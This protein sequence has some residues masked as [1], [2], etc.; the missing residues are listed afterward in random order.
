MINTIVKFTGIAWLALSLAAAAAWAGS[1]KLS[2]DLRSR[3]LSDRLDVIVRYNVTPTDAHHGKVEKQGG[4]LRDK[5]DVIKAGHY[6][7]PRSA[8]DTLSDDPDAAYISPNRGLKAMLDISAGAVHADAANSLGFVGK[9]IGVAVIDSGIADMPDFQNNRSRIVYA[10]SFVLGGISDQYG[11][12]THVAGIIGGNGNGGV[13]IGM[14]PEVNLINLRALDA[15]GNGTDAQVI[16]AIGAAINLRARFNIRVINLSLGRAVFEPAAQD[17]LC[18][19]VEAAWK[20]GIVV[21]VAAGN[22]GRDNYTTAQG[23][24]TIT[25]PG[26]DPYAITVGAMKTEGTKTRTDDLIASYS[27]KGPTLF[28]HYVKPDLVAPGNRVV[29]TMPARLVLSGGYPHGHVSGNYFTLSGTSMASAVVSGAA[30]LL[31]QKNP[32]LTPDQIKASLMRTATSNFPLSSVATDSATGTNYTSY[33]D[34][35]TV[36]AGYLDITGALAHNTY[37]A[38][39][40]LSPSASYDAINRDVVL[41][42]SQSTVGG[43]YVVTGTNVVWGSD[44]NVVWGGGSAGTSAFNAIW[45][46]NVVWSTAQLNGEMLSVLGEQ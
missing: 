46:Y 19:A 34:V 2:S 37:A 15:T 24:G 10:A 16:Q 4:A 41:N 45:G 21:V 20:A 42:G 17:P 43:T 18:Q 5:L 9:G 3:N 13:Y 22:Q 14:A 12:G 8:L 27:S 26:N 30:A 33:Y 11:H 1:E 32:L 29:S 25:A 35:F 44:K 40:A 6:T 28:D 39:S 23:Y 36:G 31:L 38:G 7:I